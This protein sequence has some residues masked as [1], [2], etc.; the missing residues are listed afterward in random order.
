MRLFIHN[1]VALAKEHKNNYAAVLSMLAQKYAESDLEKN[2]LT[3]FLKKCEV[4]NPK[5]PQDWNYA[6]LKLIQLIVPCLLGVVLMVALCG[7]IFPHSLFPQIHKEINYSHKVKGMGGKTTFDD[8]IVGK[9]MNIPVDI[10]DTEM[11]YNIKS[12]TKILIGPNEDFDVIT[13]LEKGHTVRITGYT[14]D[15]IWYR[16]MLDN[17][18]NGFTRGK[19]LTKGIGA[20]VPDNSKVY[21]KP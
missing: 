7:A 13:T 11:L 12:D 18:E 19:F 6:N 15:K 5:S 1:A 8:V 4:E 21:Q 17:G 10:N 16:V 20:P 2:L 3:Q 9:I 14:P